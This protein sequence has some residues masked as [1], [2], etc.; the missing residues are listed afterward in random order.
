[1]RK[2]DDNLIR[3]YTGGLNDRLDLI[4]KSLTAVEDKLEILDTGAEA[5]M[6]FWDSPACRQWRGEL[7]GK[8]DQ[9]KN[10]TER[11]DGLLLSVIEIAG[12]LEEAEK[13]NRFLVELTAGG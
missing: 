11:M 12:M 1:M 10:C 2:T 8:L 9:V 4:E 3:L 6:V 7:K 5:L 13:R